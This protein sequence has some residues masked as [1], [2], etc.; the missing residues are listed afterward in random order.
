MSETIIVNH[1]NQSKR[2]SELNKTFDTK[3]TVF[4]ETLSNEM[5]TYVDKS[6]I[7]VQK[8][9]EDIRKTI[10]YFKSDI[11]RKIDEFTNLPLANINQLQKDVNSVKQNLEKIDFKGLSEEYSRE[12]E[13]REEE[14]KIQTKKIHEFQSNITKH[15]EEVQK[16]AA[17]TSND[18]A[19]PQTRQ[20]TE[21]ARILLCMDSNRKFI[22]FRKLWTLKGSRKHNCSTLTSVKETLKRE[23]MGKLDY[24][25]ISVGIND[26][27]TKEPRI[28]LKE[29][30]DIINLLR[31]KHAGIKII[32]SEITPRKDQFI[33]QVVE[34]NQLLKDLCNVSDYL[35]LVD[36]S[37]LFNSN[38][39]DILYD[40]RHLHRR[41]IP[42]FAGNIKRALRKAYGLPEPRKILN[43]MTGNIP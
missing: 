40:T 36:H 39:N 43:R 24:C 31:R 12:R 8:A 20:T 19:V 26:I 37:N 4:L 7:K 17:K 33:A 2:I 28:I 16:V 9:I 6:I 11:Q 3:I 5:K 13:V 18:R 35:F 42:R 21:N 38:V 22:N 15:L 41:V 1:D 29:Y 23:N 25:F 34:L 14:S 30:E 32:V 10:A 27:D